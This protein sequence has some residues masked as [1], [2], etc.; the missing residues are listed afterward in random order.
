MAALLRFAFAVSVLA[1]A[2]VCAGT[3]RADTTTP[4]RDDEA[5]P[6]KPHDHI[7]FTMGFLGGQRAYDGLGF[8]FDGTSPAS[9]L[10]GAE[11]LTKP[12]GAPPFTSVNMLGVRYEA[13]VTIAYARMTAG[14][15][16]PFSSYR[17]STTGGVYDVG[18]TAR[19]VTIDSLSAKEGHFG[20]GLEIPFGPVAPFVDLLGGAHWVNTDLTIDG[21]RASYSSTAFAFSMRG[22]ARV[23]MRRW[24]FI[25]GAG[26]VGLVGDLKW[27]AELSVG[28]AFL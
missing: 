18:G 8:T 14:F 11:K 15:D 24:F 28:A 13:R 27:N 1:T 19:Q 22:G 23:Y 21:K 17:A 3:A 5:R 25:Q 2:I 9:A 10:G 12:F 16:L 20:L 26:E 7:E 4:P 6:G